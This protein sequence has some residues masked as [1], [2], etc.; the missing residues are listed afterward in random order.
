MD[1]AQQSVSPGTTVF[2]FTHRRRQTQLSVTTTHLLSFKTDSVIVTLFVRRRYERWPVPAPLGH[3]ELNTCGG[4]TMRAVQLAVAIA[5]V[6]A[7]EVLAT[8]PKV[9]VPV[10]CFGHNGEHFVCGYVQSDPDE[11]QLESAKR[12]DLEREALQLHALGLQRLEEGNVAA[13]RSFFERAARAG[14]ARSALALADTYD[15]EELRKLKVIGLQPDVDLARK[16]YETAYELGAIG[17]AAERLQRL[18][19]R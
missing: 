16:W 19:A 12:Q 13:A 8:P 6:L 3:R 2:P 11:V 18:G 15:P 1:F 5:F 17:E 4:P 7:S 10:L 14:L 9:Q